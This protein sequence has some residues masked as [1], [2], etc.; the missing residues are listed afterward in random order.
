MKVCFIK[1]ESERNDLY[2]LFQNGILQDGQ[3]NQITML[4]E[5]PW[6]VL[7]FIGPA[8]SD[9][10][11]AKDYIQKLREQSQ[12]LILIYGRKDKEGSHALLE[13]GADHY[14]EPCSFPEFSARIKAALRRVHS[15]EAGTILVSGTLTV[16]PLRDEVFVNGQKCDLTPI[17]LRLLVFFVRDPDQAFSHNALFRAGWKEE[18]DDTAYTLV[19]T[20]VS[21][22]RRKL[23]NLGLSED[24]F[25]TVRGH[26]YRFVG[27]QMSKQ[28]QR[29]VS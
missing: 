7:I 27:P 15:S 11:Q 13:A 20:H 5:N 18:P 25:Q 9:A 26:G 2:Q 6:A 8:F 21:H 3:A 10:Q 29:A 12:V 14:I 16:N 24:Y 22:L 4:P 23:E 17:E 1:P 28:L 19:K